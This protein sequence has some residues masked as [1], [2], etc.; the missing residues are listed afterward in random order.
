MAAEKPAHPRMSAT[1]LCAQTHFPKWE[2]SANN[3]LTIGYNYYYNNI[4]KKHPQPS[5]TMATLVSQIYAEAAPLDGRTLIR[6]RTSKSLGEL[7]ELAF[8]YKAATLGFGVAKPLGDNEPFDFILNSGHRLWR[9]Q[10]KSTYR[11]DKSGAYSLR[12]T[13][14]A[15]H[16]KPRTYSS[17]MIDIL[18]GW[19]MPLDVWYI[20]PVQAF[21]PRRT[22]AVYPHRD[23]AAGQFEPFREAWCLLA[24]WKEGACDES[25]LIDRHCRSANLRS[26]T[27]DCDLKDVI[28]RLQAQSP[29]HKPRRIR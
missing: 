3:L 1:D 11:Q 16:G 9:V 12:T 14:A 5:S 19:V 2:A 7:A 26:S 20:I 10:V 27:C 17:E 28:A 13:R 22:L 4:Y 23:P 21:A 24:C 18:A 15:V 25:L 29:D 8:L 6:H